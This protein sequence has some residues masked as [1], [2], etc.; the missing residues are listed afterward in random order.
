MHV[1]VLDERVVARAKR[2]GIDVLV[3]APHFVR[4]PEIRERAERFSDEDLLVVPARE[5]FTGDWRHRKHVLA[6]G[7]EEPV[8][9]FVTLS[10]AF[11]E[12]RRQDAVVLAPHPEFATV[13]LSAADIRDRSDD[14]DAVETYNAK[15]FGRHNRAA[16]DVARE[17]GKPGFGSSYAHLRGTVGEAWTRFEADIADEAALLTALRE[18]RPREVVRRSGNEH[19][20]RGAVE[21]AHL[22]YENSWK[23]LDRIFLSGTEPTHPSHI[24]Y[25]GRFDDVSVY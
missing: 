7:L 10:G 21:F 5:V 13:S 11:R 3:Y 24:A 2:R 6:L 8:P 4:L 19:R 12:F 14:I 23:K 20:L 9:D 1:K 16:A 18:H 15:L 25:G 17:T 22:G